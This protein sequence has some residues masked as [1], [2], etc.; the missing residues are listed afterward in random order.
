MEREVVVPIDQCG[1]FIKF[2][3]ERDIRLKEKPK[4]E[5]NKVHLKFICS[6]EV[7]DFIEKIV[8]TF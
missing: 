8:K 3:T 6:D 7:F 5:D 2:L 4:E 1:Y